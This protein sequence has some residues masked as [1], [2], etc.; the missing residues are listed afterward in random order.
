M[1]DPDLWNRQLHPHD[2]QRVIAEVAASHE[3]GAPFSSEYRMYTRAGALLWFHDEAAVIRDEDGGLLLVGGQDRHHCSHAEGGESTDPQHPG[4][5]QRRIL[6]PR[7][8]WR[9]TYVNP[10]AAGLLQRPAA[11]LVGKN[12][13]EEVPELVGSTFH[14][15]YHRV[16]NERVTV[17][18]EAYYPPLNR[19]Y[20]ARGY[21]ARSGMSVLFEDVTE[22][23][24]AGSSDA[25]RHLACTQRGAR[26]GRG[27][28]SRG[29]GAT[30]ADA[31]RP[32]QPHFLRSRLRRGDG[33]RSERRAPGRGARDAPADARHPGSCRRHRRTCALRAGSGGRA[34]VA[35]RT[36]ARTRTAF[37]RLCVCRCAAPSRSSAC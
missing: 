14:D 27:V 30:R 20:R 23:A 28:P 16:M 32:L 33:G 25:Q 15:Q 24:R 26:R 36:A 9:F 18:V 1:S 35:D 12:I 34:A 7:S 21:P 19:W 11:D 29:G 22:T 13:W 8:S 6:R 3:T 2:R 10:I 5:Y 37:V 31:V 4:G 17:E